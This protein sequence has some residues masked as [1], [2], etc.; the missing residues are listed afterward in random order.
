M[1]AMIISYKITK[2]IGQFYR[3]R[4]IC[5][6]IYLLCCFAAYLV[7]SAIVKN[8]VNAEDCYCRIK[9]EIYI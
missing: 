7:I 2:K 9:E 8:L 4:K 6:F 3:V 1:I 5:R